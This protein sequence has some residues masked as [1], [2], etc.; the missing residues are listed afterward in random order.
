MFARDWTHT[1]HHIRPRPPPRERRRPEP[2]LLVLG[3][4]TAAGAAPEAG[5]G[6]VEHAE[7]E[8]HLWAKG[9][10]SSHDFQHVPLSADALAAAD[11]AADEA[12]ELERL[13]QP[14]DIVGGGMIDLSEE[15]GDP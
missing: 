9:G 1:S 10:V 11:L 13:A 8:G 5:L 12:D 6:D 2:V 3:A 14:P 15:L 7:G 4:S